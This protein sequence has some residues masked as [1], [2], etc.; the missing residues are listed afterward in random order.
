M[1]D[2]E[3]GQNAGTLPHNVPERDA[4][5]LQR[6]TLWER[7]TAAGG[8]GDVLRA[9]RV[10]WDIVNR[11]DKR[12]RYRSRIA[13]GTVAAELGHVG[14]RDGDR[15]G[16]D[17]RRVARA[18]RDRER[19][20]VLRDNPHAVP[21]VPR[22]HML[23]VARRTGIVPRNRRTGQP[24]PRRDRERD[25]S[26]VVSPLT[27]YAWKRDTGTVARMLPDGTVEVT[28]EPIALVATRA[29]LPVLT[30]PLW[31]RAPC[32]C[33]VEEDGTHGIACPVRAA[34]AARVT[35]WDAIGP[36][37]GRATVRALVDGHAWQ[38]S[39]GATSPA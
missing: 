2:V 35:A 13:W 15:I 17:V 19:S 27:P 12:G 20:D 14:D 18:L 11:P 36:R 26:P 1:P 23:T 4:I 5:P 31:T 6:G 29:T 32:P 10:A 30:V 22:P 38:R 8:T 9:A 21:T 3:D 28:R 7:L 39:H 37:T 34:R 16:R 25:T 33:S 24:I